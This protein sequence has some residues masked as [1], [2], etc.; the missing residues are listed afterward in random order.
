M[1][2]KR[3]TLTQ[4]L[5]TT[6]IFIGLGLSLFANDYNHKKSYFDHLVEINKE[7][8]HHKS[9]CPEGVI[10]FQSDV[11]RIQLH[12]NLVIDYLKSNTPIEFNATQKSNRFYLLNKLQEYA[13]QKV[14]PIN[15]HHSIRT[16]YFVDD[17]GTNCA[18]GQ[19][20]YV[21]GHKDLVQRISRA[22]NYDYIKDIDTE[23]LTEWAQQYGFK[24]EELKWIQP[25]Y[26]PTRIIEQIG[27][28]TNGS[29]NNIVYNYYTHSL[30]VSGNFTELDS[31]PCLNIGVYKNDQLSCLGNG[32]EGKIN[33]VVVNDGVIY[34]FGELHHNGD[35]FPIAKHE[36][37]GWSYINIPN[38]TG[39]ICTAANRGGF[40]YKFELSISHSTIPEHQ[41]IWRFVDANTW[42]KKAMVKGFIL[43]IITS[44]QGKVYAG[45]FDSVTVYDSFN[46][47]DTTLVG[48]NVVIHPSYTNNW[49]GTG[50]EISDTVKTIAQIGNALIFGGS[51]SSSS[52]TNNICI[53]RY[54]NST[55]Q[56]LYLN[57]SPSENYSINAITYNHGNKFTFGG[58]FEIIP[59]VGT[60]GNNLATYDLVYNRIEAIA[61]LDQPVHS[62]AYLNNEM[63]LG[64]EFHVNNYSQPV[65]HLGK[66]GGTVGL[67][68][69]KIDSNAGIYP[70][71]FTSTINIRNIEDG[72]PFTIQS[73]NGREVK[74]G[75]VIDQR[76]NGLETL[77]KGTYLLVLETKKGAVIK[78]VFK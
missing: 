22:H 5:F 67:Y 57:Y 33:D 49:Y 58:K 21:S 11:N 75:T 14:F 9:A 32:V 61:R 65:N 41:E 35:T 39:A 74:R 70:N 48:K 64:G 13:D 52:G 26:P 68:E 38:R 46:T 28:G 47:V 77:P 53:S 7:W 40:E 59:V 50:T 27:D 63:F 16:P 71:P 62:L 42:E 4:I 56:P 20:I 19:M 66:L 1:K 78:K 8:N 25:G 51:C 60:I 36:G 34:A 44:S 10:S 15:N 6:F 43:D 2:P 3:S 29:V 23:G 54:Y 73:I 31:L 55:L 30:I 17:Y 76:I 37:S 69:N 12:L 45:H 18:V 24:L 72:V